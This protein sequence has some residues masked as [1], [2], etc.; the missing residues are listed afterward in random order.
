M[1][2]F[3]RLHPSG[4]GKHG[5]LLME[6][7]LR[8]LGRSV[9]DRGSQRAARQEGSRTQDGR[10]GCGMAGRLALP[11]VAA[12]QLHSSQAHPRTARLDP[13]PAQAGRK[14]S[15][16]TQPTAE[17]AGDGQHQVVQPGHGCVRCLRPID[18]ARSDRGQ[19]HPAGN[20]QLAKRR[21]RDK[22]P[23]LELALEGNFCST[24]N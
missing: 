1:V 21:L 11:W 19:S 18:A 5:R 23:E 15:G 3:G 12:P 4:D 20:G 13:L 17:A 7:G 22:I 2:A 10:E 14:S 24:Y 6:A 9:A 16:R 8:P